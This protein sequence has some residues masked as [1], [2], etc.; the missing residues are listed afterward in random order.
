MMSSIQCGFDVK[1]VFKIEKANIICNLMQEIAGFLDVA[2]WK[3]PV[4]VHLLAF[5]VGCCKLFRKD[6][7]VNAGMFHCNHLNLANFKL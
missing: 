6:R 2:E 1:I 3:V 4:G 7:I 5:S